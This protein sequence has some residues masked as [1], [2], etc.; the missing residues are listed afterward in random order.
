MGEKVK[1]TI[2]VNCINDGT[3]KYERHKTACLDSYTIS[4]TYIY[5]VYKLV[6]PYYLTI[7]TKATK[8]NLEMDF[9]ENVKKRDR[10]E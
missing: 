8:L 3:R 2:Q 5:L 6:L 7:P 9:G 1:K 10:S 4:G